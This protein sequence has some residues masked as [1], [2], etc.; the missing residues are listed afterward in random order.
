MLFQVAATIEN[1]STRKDRTMK[2]VIGTQELLPAQAAMLM[3]LY[4]KLG[5]F[6]FRENP[7]EMSDVPT[8]A[9]PEFKHE[10]NPMASLSRTIYIFWDK[11]T[12]KSKPFNEFLREWVEKKKSEI[13]EYLPK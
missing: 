5:W 12:D 11:C 8:E 10:E 2:V 3:E 6:M 13:K 1:V 4:D 7:F 9:A